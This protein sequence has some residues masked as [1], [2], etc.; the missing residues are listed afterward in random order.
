MALAPVRYPSGVT[1]RARNDALGFFPMP[2]PTRVITYYNDFHTY[3][4]AEWTV[5]ETDAASTQALSAGAAGGVLLLT[6]DVTTA[7][8]VNQAQLATESF[9]IVVGKQLWLKTRFALTASTMNNFGALIGLAITDTSAVVAVTDGFYFRKSTGAATLEFVTEKA[10]TETAS[11]TIATLV[12]ATYVTCAAYYNGKDSIEVW[13]DDVKVATITTLTNLPD[14]EE[15]A[16]TIAAVNAT[17][18][19]ANVLSVDYVL[20]SVER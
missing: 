5:T 15:L 11:G 12:T 18:G 7:T 3:A 1:N 19:A 14:T 17:A 2:D 6:H 13:V 16:V 8:A 4:A 10:S 20:V 9:K